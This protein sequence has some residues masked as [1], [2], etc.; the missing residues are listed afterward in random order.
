MDFLRSAPLRCLP[1]ILWR[2]A[3]GIGIPKSVDYLGFLLGDFLLQP[4]KITKCLVKQHYLRLQEMVVS[5]D[6]FRYIVYSSLLGKD[7]IDWSW[8]LFLFIHIFIVYTYIYLYTPFDHCPSNFYYVHCCFS[9][10]YF[11][12]TT[13]RTCSVG[14]MY[15]PS[16]CRNM[17]YI[18]T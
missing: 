9:D 5:I 8:Y 17:A 1:W 13:L 10:G 16:N 18:L 3:V 12:E 7:L 6:L 2:T 15:W 11:C 14:K 4:F